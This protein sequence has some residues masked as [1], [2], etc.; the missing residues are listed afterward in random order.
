M[1]LPIEQQTGKKT[2]KKNGKND[3]LG[4]GLFLQFSDHYWYQYNSPY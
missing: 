2:A 3:E 1:S 4:I